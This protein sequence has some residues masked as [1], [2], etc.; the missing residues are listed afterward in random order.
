MCSE[1]LELEHDLQ[2]K[3]FVLSFPTF[4]SEKH[5]TTKSKINKSTRNTMI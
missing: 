1:V 3:C 5:T 4:I 2:M